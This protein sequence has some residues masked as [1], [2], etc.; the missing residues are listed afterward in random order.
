MV[1]RV[2][3]PSVVAFEPRAVVIF[4]V[5]VIGFV[6]EPPI[7]G[8]LLFFIIL[9]WPILVIVFIWA[10]LFI[11]RGS[12]LTVSFIGVESRSPASGPLSLALCLELESLSLS[13]FLLGFFM[14]R[15]TFPVD[16]TGV[17]LILVGIVAI[18]GLDRT[19]SAFVDR[20]AAGV[21]SVVTSPVN[22]EIVVA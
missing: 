6:V 17:R 14:L 15:T 11:V 20:V 1:V 19:S 2:V 5:V 7:T 22:V 4:V 21:P 13:V 16:L 9:V 8:G 18:L 12:V 3:V 10:I